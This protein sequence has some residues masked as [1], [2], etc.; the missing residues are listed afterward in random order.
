MAVCGALCF[1]LRTISTTN[2]TATI[3]TT[4]T[5]MMIISIIGNAP[6]LLVEMLVLCSSIVAVT[7]LNVP[8]I[9]TVKPELR[10]THS[11]K[12]ELLSVILI[13]WNVPAGV[14]TEPPSE[15]PWV[16]EVNSLFSSLSVEFEAIG[17]GFGD[18]NVASVVP[19]STPNSDKS[20][21]LAFAV[22]VMLNVFAAVLTLLTVYVTCAFTDTPETVAVT[23]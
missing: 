12:P 9:L 3:A 7:P 21:P 1:R 22:V 15:T 19:V 13:V 10:S 18:E 11:D 8:D 4:T 17:S 23:W 5:T 20:C 2:S 16:P 6:A 14:V